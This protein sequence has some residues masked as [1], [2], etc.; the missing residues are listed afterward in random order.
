[1][2]DVQV[3]TVWPVIKVLAKKFVFYT[4]LDNNNYK[5]GLDTLLSFKNEINWTSI[6][7][8]Q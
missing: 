6:Y 3:T 5:S 7:A 1:M 2:L 8:L 4:H